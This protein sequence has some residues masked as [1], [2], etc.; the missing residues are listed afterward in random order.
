M[1]NN[2]RKYIIVDRSKVHPENS[3]ID[4]FIRPAWVFFLRG[5]T[6]MSLDLK[7]QTDVVFTDFSKDFDSID[8]I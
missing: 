6:D 1:S 4:Y 2:S 8:L 7:Q 3:T 5:P